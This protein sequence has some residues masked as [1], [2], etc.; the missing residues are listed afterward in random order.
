MCEVDKQRH[1][2]DQNQK[3]PC[4]PD[5]L[6]FLQREAPSALHKKRQ[7]ECPKRKMHGVGI[8]GKSKGLVAEF[9]DFENGCKKHRSACPTEDHEFEAS[10]RSHLLIIAPEREGVTFAPINQIT[11]VVLALCHA[12]SRDASFTVRNG[13]PAERVYWTLNTGLGWEIETELWANPRSARLTN[14]TE[15]P[16]GWGTQHLSLVR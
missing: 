2:C 8:K 6:W 16:G 12:L 5:P 15:N 10:Q 1:R 7:G 9:A 11:L 14:F 13:D 3:D 4:I